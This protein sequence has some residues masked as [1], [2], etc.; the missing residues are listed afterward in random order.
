MSF[1]TFA[2]ITRH[3][4]VESR[5]FGAAAIC[6]AD[7]TIVHQWGDVDSLIFPRSALKPALAIALIESGAADAYQL[8]DA[9]LA[10]AC[11]SHNGEP[12]HSDGVAAWLARLGL[13]PD[14][15]ACGSVLPDDQATVHK[16]LAQGQGSCRI[17]HNCSGKHVGFLTY[18]LHLG[19]PIKGH[20]LRTHPAQQNGLDIL[21]DLANVDLCS[22]PMGIDGC[23]FP[24]P[25][26]PLAKLAHMV[27]SFADPSKLSV[28]RSKAIYRLHQAMSH[29][30]FHVSGHGSVVSDVMHV[31]K[32][33]ILVKSGAE[34]I[35][36]A[37]IPSL[38]LGIALKIA[39]GSARAR[40]AVLLAMLK[41][42]DVLSDVELDQLH[43]HIKP[44]IFNS[45][46]EFVG[47]I[48]ATIHQ[49]KSQWA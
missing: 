9:E 32:G 2:E 48:R 37:A 41:S 49:E 11:A 1:E 15:L 26:M 20:H 8:S 14:D 30:P 39:D 33:K 34:G 5:H 31:T 19:L 13:T 45:R 18:C 29:K 46:H 3:N 25:T 38:G 44:K 24:A 40:G 28:E 6:D 4:I 43:N 27:A 47:E 17:H 10:L 21:S 23:G 35:M 36:T 12:I 16:I 7:G 22:S 42:L